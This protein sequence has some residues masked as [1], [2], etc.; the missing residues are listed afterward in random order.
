MER[1]AWTLENTIR[2]NWARLSQELYEVDPL[3][4]PN[5]FKKMKIISFIITAH[6]KRGKRS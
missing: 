3:T 2:R 5:S 6:E 1:A 4:C